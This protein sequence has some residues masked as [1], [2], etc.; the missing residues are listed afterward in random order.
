MECG[1]CTF[2]CKVLYI[3]S[4][5]KKAGQDCKHC[6]FSVGCKIHGEHPTEC[7][8]F[9]CAY[10]QASIV[11]LELRPDMC[12]IMF[13]RFDNIMLGTMDTKDNEAYK[14]DIVQRQLQNFLNEGFSI[15]VYSANIEKP[16]II[17]A[18]NKTSKEVWS[19]FKEVS[20]KWLHMA[21]I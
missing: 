15:V 18:K 11:S 9:K 20:I 3:P 16:I 7:K 8:E 1:G 19:D 17:P 21:Q 6:N 10:N 2:C 12:G 13:E 14:K 5:E 4:L